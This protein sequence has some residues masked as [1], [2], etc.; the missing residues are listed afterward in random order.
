MAQ[1]GFMSGY[2]GNYFGPGDTITRAQ[3]AKVATSVGGLHTNIVENAGAPTFS[4]VALLHDS[5]GNPLSYPFDYVEE[6]AA[7][8]LVMG[9]GD[10]GAAMAFRPNEAI[11]RVQLAQILAR[12]V[13]Q[14]KG[15]GRDG[16]TPPVTTFADVPDY[17]VADVALVA[18][19]GLMS[20]YSA[21]TFSPW[22]GAQRAQ[23]AMA[24]SRYLDLPAAELEPMDQPGSE[25]VEEPQVQPA[26]ELGF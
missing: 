21:T 26:P 5:A 8:G 12:M 9:S 15:Y 7:A 24:M 20:G 4:D 2:D 18:E 1:E 11:S 10:A 16:E 14:L 17:A 13:R 6:A 22:P 3:V 23:V 19:L 25:P